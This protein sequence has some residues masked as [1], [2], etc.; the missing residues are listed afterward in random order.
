MIYLKKEE[1]PTTCVQR[2]EEFKYKILEKRFVTKSQEQMVKQYIFIFLMWIQGSQLKAGIS[3]KEIGFIFKEMM[4]RLFGESESQARTEFLETSS[5]L[6]YW[7][8]E[9]LM[10]AGVEY[11]HENLWLASVLLTEQWDWWWPLPTPATAPLPDSTFS[12]S[13]SPAPGS[14]KPS[15]CPLYYVRI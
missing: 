8:H 4:E 14:A 11:S 13:F 1:F 6:S 10:S 12:W 7:Q 15:D 2:S 5:L 9:C 3:I